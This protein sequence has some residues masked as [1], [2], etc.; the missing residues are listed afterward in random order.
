MNS[1]IPPTIEACM[2]ARGDRPV[3]SLRSDGENA[4]MRYAV[5]ASDTTPVLYSIYAEYT[6]DGKTTSETIPA[7]SEERDT[8]DSFCAMLWRF[9][10]TPLSLHAHYEDS[11]TP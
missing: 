9:G 3:L 5:G 10:V 2:K 4:V 8:A 6:A 1:D 7:F 11:L